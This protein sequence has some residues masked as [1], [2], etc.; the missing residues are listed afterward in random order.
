MFQKKS[1]IWFV[2]IALFLNSCISIDRKALLKEFYIMDI[3]NM[4]GMLL[5]N[6]LLEYFNNQDLQSAKY[7]IK[8]E[9][10]I[11]N[12]VDLRDKYGIESQGRLDLTLYFKVIEKKSNLILPKHH[13]K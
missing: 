6:N 1:L 11:T 7:F 3:P 5:K 8:I 10:K 4:N 12:I 9:I 13:R 2:S